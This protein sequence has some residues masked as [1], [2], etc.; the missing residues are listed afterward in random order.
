MARAFLR[1]TFIALRARRQAYRIA[2]D[3]LYDQPIDVNTVACRVCGT[4][5]TRR[6]L[7][8]DYRI[9][10]PHCGAETTLPPHRRAPRNDPRR[11]TSPALDYCPP[12]PHRWSDWEMP[13]DMTVL[14]LVSALMLV[15]ALVVVAITWPK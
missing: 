14:L 3:F 13:S 2:A 8:D 1:Q 5:L 7:S 9:Y 15:G 6:V 4:D 12:E 10:C 11:R